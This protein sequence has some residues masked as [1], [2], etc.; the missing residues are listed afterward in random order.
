MGEGTLDNL[1]ILM[2]NR[3]GL[4]KLPVSPESMRVVVLTVFLMPCNWIGRHIVLLFKGATSTLSELRREDVEV[5][6]LLKNPV[7]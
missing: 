2:G 3:Q 1:K 5:T 7:L 4:M 6:L